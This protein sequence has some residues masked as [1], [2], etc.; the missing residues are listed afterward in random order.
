MLDCLSRAASLFRPS[1]CWPLPA[2]P[3]PD[4]EH[5]VRHCSVV[6]RLPR[7]VRARFT[8]V[9]PAARRPFPDLHSPTRSDLC[10][11]P[12]QGPALPIPMSAVQLLVTRPR[13]VSRPLRCELQSSGVVPPPAPLQAVP[14]DCHRGPARSRARLP[15][16][17]SSARLRPGARAVRIVSIRPLARVAAS[18]P[19]PRRCC[20]PSPR[21]SAADTS[22]RLRAESESLLLDPSRHGFRA[23]VS[24]VARHFRRD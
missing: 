12:Y 21:R 19:S 23:A 24:L 6:P 3:L 20:E 15:R 18:A 22:R 11:P 8:R 4:C 5:P 9:G 17:V 13:S 1:R 14:A 7:T 10:D 2:L 16:S